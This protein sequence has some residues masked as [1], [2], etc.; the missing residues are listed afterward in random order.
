M[1]AGGNGQRLKKRRVHT[2]GG[3]EALPAN[4]KLAKEMTTTARARLEQARETA[5]TNG[6]RYIVGGQLGSGDWRAKAGREASVRAGLLAGA[7]LNYFACP[8][9]LDVATGAVP[10]IDR[11]ARRHKRPRWRR[12]GG[13]AWAVFGLGVV[14]VRGNAK[15]GHREDGREGTHA[16]T[17]T[18]RS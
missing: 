11:D 17:G 8:G 4:L 2:S 1:P 7:D 18:R 16:N 10:E 14:D 15:R 12:R 5:P 6:D 13:L 9:E 3:K